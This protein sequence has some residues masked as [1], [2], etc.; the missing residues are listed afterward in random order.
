MT[1]E[2]FI[3][4]LSVGSA[5]V[6]GII[7]QGF[8][9]RRKMSAEMTETLQKAASGL[10]K[11]LRDD[12]LAL[13]EDNKTLHQDLKATNKALRELGTKVGNLERQME[14]KDHQILELEEEVREWRVFTLEILGQLERVRPSGIEV[15]HPTARIAPYL[16]RPYFP[17]DPDAE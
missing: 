15:P 9:S 1:A 8:F 13:R 12:N 6:L 4:I 14:N 5:G 11:D 2:V 7:I 3:T 10:T 17:Q 16:K